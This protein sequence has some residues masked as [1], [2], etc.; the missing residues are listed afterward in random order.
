MME[1]SLSDELVPGRGTVDCMLEEC[2]VGCFTVH[3]VIVC[4]LGWLADTSWI[5]AII[6][7]TVPVQYEFGMSDTAAGA[8]LPILFGAQAVGALVF[9][10]IAD[11]CGRRGVFSVTLI[12]SGVA[13][14]VAAASNS[15]WMLVAAIALAGFGVGG[16]MP[17][18]GAIAIELC[19]KSMRGRLM[20]VLTVFWSMGSILMYAVAWSLIPDATCEAPPSPCDPASNR[21][22]RHVLWALAATCFGSLIPRLRF[23]ESPVWLCA[24]GRPE[25]AARVL[26]TVAARN[27]RVMRTELAAAHLRRR[28]FS[29]P[30]TCAER[31][32][33]T[34]TLTV[35][36]AVSV[37]ADT[38][39]GVA[40]EGGEREGG[41]RGTPEDGMTHWGCRGLCVPSHDWLTVPWMKTTFGI[42]LA[43]WFLSNFGYGLFNS[44]NIVLV[45]D[46]IGAPPT[47]DAA[48][49]DAMV[50]AS[51][52]P[53]GALLGAYL[54]DTWL[55]RKW[56]LCASVLLVGVSLGCFYAAH[57]EATIVACGA[58][59]QLNAQIM[60]A[61]LYLYSPE[62]LPTSVRGCG[63]GL[64]SGVSRVAGILAPLTG[65]GL[66]ASGVPANGIVALAIGC[67]SV[68][69]LCAAL[70]PIETRGC[71]IL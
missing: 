15:F 54:V 18:D 53:I 10:P 57:S 2:G 12:I 31:S 58:L 42:L 20:T 11:T 30:D 60:Y 64:L 9:G 25:E 34:P 50:Q 7:I 47:G 59:I 16:N 26:Q 51:A 43:L 21:G 65:H 17:I 52:G 36:V 23:P 32:V 3:L 70:L 35:N 38:R 46:K 49:R 69:A 56:T 62:V 22:W 67:M 41:G 55:G 68:M 19:P 33:S 1:G 44:M 27:G 71:D 24:Q 29:T 40:R 66:A 6:A 14:S 45:T 48:Y 61:A 5:T 8:L 13:G 63:V 37:P 39:E 28:P 4:G